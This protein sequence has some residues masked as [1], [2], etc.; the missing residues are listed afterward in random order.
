MGPADRHASRHDG[1]VHRQPLLG[2][3]ACL[4]ILAEQPAHG[5]AVAARLR[6]DGDIGRIWQL[7]RP[8]TYRSL[9]QLGERGWVVPVA[10]EPGDAGPNRT[11]L[12]TT[13]TGRSRL[14]A[15]LRTPVE[16][17]RDLRSELVLKLVFAERLGADLGDMLERQRSI[18]DRH[19]EALAAASHADPGD[20][21]ALWRVESTRAA[22]RFLD[23]VTAR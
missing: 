23:R 16:H 5:W 22:Q 9:D 6:A 8:L 21:V 12:A 19:A 15:W 7:S 11:I 18:V 3:W 13:R 20:V 1:S 4:G 2:E 14:R 17:Q 10:E